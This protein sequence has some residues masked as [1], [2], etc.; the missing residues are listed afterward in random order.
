MDNT[1]FITLSTHNVN[2]YKR[3][4]EFL[5]SQCKSNA[6]SIRAIQ[7]HWLR[8]PYKKQFGVNQLRCLHAE[9]DGYGSS[10]MKKTMKLKSLWVV[11][12]G[13]L[14]FCFTKNTQVAL[15]HTHTHERVSV[16][17]L[18][19]ESGPIILFSCYF[20]FFNLREI[21]NYSAMYKDTVGFIDNVM[22]SCQDAKFI[23][24]ADFN[25]NIHNVNHQYTK[26]LLP[27]LEKYGLVSAFSTD[28]DF[29]YENSYT[30]YDSK[31]S[32]FTLIDGILLSEDLKQK[33]KR[34][35]ICHSGNN[36]SDHIPVEMD[37]SVQVVESSLLKPKLQHYVN[38][39][40]LKSIGFD[41]NQLEC[42]GKG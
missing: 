22:H 6:N 33:V 37:L 2:G 4:K 13:G 7:E 11:P 9:F 17:E 18:S 41:W 27:L 39:S 34:V 38:W 21:D 19:T 31:T 26:I 40:K 25:C 23:V 8:P 32:S 30:R 1:T 24:L 14:N 5:L 28:P 15:N 29:D 42:F 12:L 16:M 35:S 20:P 3:S 36:V 10:A